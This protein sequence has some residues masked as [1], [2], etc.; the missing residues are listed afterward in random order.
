MTHDAVMLPLGRAKA[1]LWLLAA[2]EGNVPDLP[3]EHAGWLR[4]MCLDVVAESL[5]ETEDAYVKKA[6]KVADKAAD[7]AVAS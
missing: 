7:K 6:G 1:A 3:D 4:D 5:Q 2:M